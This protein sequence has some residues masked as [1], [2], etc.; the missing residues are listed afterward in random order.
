MAPSGPKHRSLGNRNGSPSHAVATTSH[1][2]SMVS[3]SREGV[4]D[5][6]T[7]ITPPESTARPFGRPVCLITDFVWP[8]ALIWVTQPRSAAAST[9]SH[10]P[11]GKATGPSGAPRSRA[12]IIE[13]LQRLCLGDYTSARLYLCRL[14]AIDVQHRAGHE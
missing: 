12:K 8:S 9:T 14:S 4:L 5:S 6:A 2:P 7:Q 3:R 1:F 13:I 11:S 10:V